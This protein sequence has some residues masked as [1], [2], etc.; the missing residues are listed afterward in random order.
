[1]Y[2]GLDVG[3]MFDELG[4][5]GLRN[6]ETTAN[7]DG[8]VTCKLTYDD[9]TRTKT[10]DPLNGGFETAQRMLISEERA[11]YLDKQYHGPRPVKPGDRLPIE[12]LIPYAIAAMPL[13]LDE[14]RNEGRSLSEL[15]KLAWEMAEAMYIEQVKRSG[16]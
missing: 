6:V 2:R 8:S 1:M 5:I 11:T 14:I 9:D 7:A 10:L 12:R 3:W 16:R 4:P 15:A 13:A